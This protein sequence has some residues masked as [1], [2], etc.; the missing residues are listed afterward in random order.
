MAVSEIVIRGAAEH[1][2]KNIDLTLPRNR[3]IVVTGVSGSGK[4]SLAFDTLY[5]EGQRRYVES[6]SAYARQFLEQME[7][8]DV[9]S[10]E[11][12]SPAISIEQKTTSRNPRSTVGTVTEIYDYLRL[13]FARIGRPHCHELRQAHH[14]PDRAADRGRRAGAA[15]RDRGSRCWPPSCAAARGPTRRRCG[16]R[17]QGV[18]AR[19]RRRRGARS[20]GRDRAGQA[21]EAHHRDRGGPA[22]GGGR[23]PEPPDGFGGDGPRG[24]RGAGRH[25]RGGEARPA[26]LAPPGLHRSAGSRCRSWRPACSP[27][28]RP[29]APVPSAADSASQQESST[30]PGSSWTRTSACATGPSPGAT[31][32]GIQVVESSLF[33][34]FKIAPGTPYKKL[35][36]AFKKLLWE[37]SGEREFDFRWKGTRTSY[38]WKRTWEGILPMLERKYRETDSEWRREELEKWMTIHP[39][40]ACGGARLRPESL[41]VHVGGQN[42]AQHTA[43][44]VSEALRSLPEPG[45]AAARGDRG[46]AHPQGDPGAAGLPGERGARLPDAWTAGRPPSPAARGSASAWPRRSARA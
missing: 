8:P 1:N 39:C 24:G 9:E 37:G 7:K 18:R 46:H 3:L 21:E 23:P 34:A 41:A 22:G 42:I 35:P 6:L 17:R 27:S 31:P 25:R 10:I 38:E 36:A 44:S 2:L 33:R 30:W 14:Q 26:V 32:T 16:T 13:L 29:T 28:T 19:P 40:P 45:A 20:V 5:A 11:G 15:G 43:Q 4:S 12:L